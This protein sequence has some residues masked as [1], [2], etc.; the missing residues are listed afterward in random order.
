MMQLLKDPILLAVATATSLPFLAMAV[1]LMFTRH[2]VR[3]SCSISV[4]AISISLLN[5]LYLLITLRHATAP[6]EYQTAW[7][8]SKGVFVSFGYLLDPLSLVMLTIV[9]TIAFLVQIYSLGYMAGDPGITR[10]YAFQSLFAWAMM[11]MVIAPGMMQLYIFWELVGLA[12]YLLIGY[13]YEKPS[14]QQAGKKAFVMTRLGDI[15]FF[16]GL[17]ALLLGYGNLN[18]LDM[19]QAAAANKIP[20][21]LL[22]ISAMLI[23]CGVIGKSA[24]FPLM[25]WL[26]DAMEGPTPVSALLHSATMVAAGVYMFSRIF[27]FFAASPNAMAMALAIGTITTLLASTMAMATYDLKQVWA[28]STISQLGFM[29]MGLAAGGY[30]AGVFHLTTH[31]GFKALLFLCSGVFIHEYHTNDMR[32]IGQQGGRKLYIPMI[33][34]TIGALALAG[35]F[36]FAGFFSKEAILGVLA[37]HPNKIWLLGGLLGAFLTAYYSFRLIFFVACP[38]PVAAGHGHE[39]GHGHGHGGHDSQD[40]HHSYIFWCMAVPLIILATVT[41]VLGF[42]QSSL[43]HFLMPQ[44]AAA[45]GGA[46]EGGHGGGHLTLLITAVSCALGGILLAW[47]EFGRKGAK[48]EGFLRRF[49]RVEELFARR[50]YMDDMLRFLLDNVVYCG[51]TS[52]FTR[53]DRRVIDGGLDGFCRFTVGSGRIASFLQSGMLQYNLMVMI[54][55]VGFI[56]LVFVSR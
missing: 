27:P 31:A 40:G 11:T 52:V 32:V 33:C 45:H 42:S 2:N 26:P 50:W 35:I 16:L 12:S 4:G 21:Y 25:T 6:I 1:I 22:T 49:V 55:A 48:Q 5:A 24:Q 47:F 19:N 34:M 30:F 23:F 41:L 54:A 3:L 28:Y 7:L 51:F 29:V 53:N 56:V 38:K 9:A 43:E 8:L 20:Q 15:G 36:P 18:I 44:S 37:A 39:E 46:H 17:V 14:A 13:Y 10:Y